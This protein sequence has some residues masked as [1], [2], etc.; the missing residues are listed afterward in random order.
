MSSGQFLGEYVPHKRKKWVLLEAHLWLVVGSVTLP[1]LPQARGG[2]T[3]P[4]IICRDQGANYF[5]P[6]FMLLSCQSRDGAQLRF[7]YLFCSGSDN[8][9]FFPTVTE[10]VIVYGKE[11][12]SQS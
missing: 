9:D 10:K 3:A 7:S 11:A 1:V 5:T 4:S 2:R 8:C 12:Q 6:V